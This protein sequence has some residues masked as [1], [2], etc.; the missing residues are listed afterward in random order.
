MYCHILRAF[1]GLIEREIQ[2]EMGTS[3]K[4]KELKRETENRRNTD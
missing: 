1:K 2:R 3:D 4:A